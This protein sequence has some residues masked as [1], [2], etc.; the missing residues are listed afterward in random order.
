VAELWELNAAALADGYKA[1]RFSPLEVAQA[2]LGRIKAL[3]KNV[4]AFCLIDEETT[5]AQARKSE[6]RWTKCEGRSALDGVP[7]AIK[8]L[9]WTKG[10]PTLRGSRTV[11]RTQAWDQ[12]APSVARLKEAGA[13]LLGKTTTPEYGWKGVT[14]GPLTGVT[15]NPWN[16]EMTPGGSSG[17]SSA[18]LAARLAP[19]ALGTDGGGSIRIP[20]SFSGVFG[21]KPT[22]GRVPAYPL[23][24]FGTLPHVGPMSRDVLGSAMLLD[25][26]AGADARDPHALPPPTDSFAREQSL[27]GKRVAFSPAMGFAKHIDSEVAAFAAAA[28]K[29]FEALGAIVEEVD[30][31]L[32]EGGD[33][34]ADFKTLWWSGAGYLFG[35]SPEEKKALFDPGFRRMVEEGAA[36]SLKRF[37]QATMAR[38]SF[39]SAM[40]QFMARYDILLT[41]AVAVPAFEVDKVSPWPDDGFAWLNW[42][43]FSLPFNL[44][45]Q[46]AASVPCGFTKAGLPVGLQIAGRMYDDAG[47]LAAAR[48]YEQADP[49]FDAAPKGFA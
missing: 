24:P 32:F 11:D 31:P 47:V 34:K 15:R 10:W 39:A 41:P 23:S 7:V 27:K 21:L 1:K 38:L 30:P 45:Q 36:I 42:T 25:V 37:Q 43:P 35:D 8:D 33:P 4:N 12:D 3:D 40:R 19:L 20:A 17:G 2:L 16:L 9:L 14:D 26:I 29:R 6:A 48:A 44:T 22:Y 28:A 49:H 18:A 13:V 5:L 46:P